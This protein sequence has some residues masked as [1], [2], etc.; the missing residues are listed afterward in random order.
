MGPSPEYQATTPISCIPLCPNWSLWR[1][2][3]HRWGEIRRGDS[4]YAVGEGSSFML[5]A[6][7][8]VQ[9]LTGHLLFC[10]EV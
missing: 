2:R 3:G 4:I 5:G 1:A 10:K 7:L 9:L 6:D 8:L